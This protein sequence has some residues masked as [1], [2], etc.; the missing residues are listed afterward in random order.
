MRNKVLGAEVR[1]IAHLVVLVGGGTNG[2]LSQIQQFGLKL[3]DW[4]LRNLIRSRDLMAE[5][6]GLK[7][8]NINFNKPTN[9]IKPRPTCPLML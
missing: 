4:E 8:L 1:V 9:N 3:L 7:G 5:T 6:A 2:G